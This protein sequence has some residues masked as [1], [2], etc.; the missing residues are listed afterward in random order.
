MSWTFLPKG[1]E[2][3]AVRLAFFAAVRGADPES[4]P[5][6]DLWLDQLRRYE[7]D[8]LPDALYVVLP[9]ESE[10]TLLYDVKRSSFH[11]VAWVEWRDRRCEEAW[12][13]SKYD[14]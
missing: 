4:E 1:L 12:D 3:S 8:Q 10:P 2:A 11:I 13:F 6:Q 9:D 7:P 14:Q 5:V